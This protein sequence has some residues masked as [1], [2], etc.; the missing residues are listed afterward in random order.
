VPW[1]ALT[2]NKADI[3][4]SSKARDRQRINSYSEDML[5]LQIKLSLKQELSLTFSLVKQ[6]MFSM[7]ESDEVRFYV[8]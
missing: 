3:W 2:K 7:V 8:T 5:N 4:K 1:V 6:Y